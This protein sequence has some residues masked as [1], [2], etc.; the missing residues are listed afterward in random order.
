MK[1]AP[2]PESRHVCLTPT[3]CCLVKLYTTAV[4]PS[5]KLSYKS[6]IFL[7]AY[8][9]QVLELSFSAICKVTTSKFTA[10][11]LLLSHSENYAKLTFVRS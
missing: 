8:A 11:L 4:V 1:C 3:V 6:M 7:S 9:N 2:S 10:K 5:R